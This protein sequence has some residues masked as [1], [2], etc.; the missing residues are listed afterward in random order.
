MSVIMSLVVEGDP[1]GVEQFDADNRATMQ[2]VLEAAQRHGLIA[3][4]FYGSDGEAR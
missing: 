1:N 4:R 2:S 3:H